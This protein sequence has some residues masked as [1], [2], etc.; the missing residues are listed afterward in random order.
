LVEKSELV[1][2]LLRFWISEQ[3]HAIRRQTGLLR[4]GTPMW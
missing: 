2:G 3:A 4:A 1:A